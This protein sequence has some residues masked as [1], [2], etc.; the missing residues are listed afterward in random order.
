[1]MKGMGYEFHEVFLMKTNI[2]A[3]QV[4]TGAKHLLLPI[5]FL[6]IALSVIVSACGGQ[7]P[8]PPTPLDALTDS[9][10]Y[11]TADD[12]SAASVLPEEQVAWA[13]E[14]RPTQAA[15]PPAPMATP[16]LPP[17]LQAQAFVNLG[18]EALHGV[19]PFTAVFRGNISYQANCAAI[20]LDT[21]D[22]HRVPLACPADE[23]TQFTLRHTYET[24]ATYYAQAIM[25]LADG[26]TVSSPTQTV[27]VAVPQPVEATARILWWSTWLL[28]VGLAAAA[29]WWCARRARRWRGW[30][31]AG[32]GLLLIT[33]VPPF[34]YL[35]DPLGL[36]WSWRGGY[37]EDT[38]LP[39]AN[40]FVQ[41]EATAALRPYL[42]GL[43]G[44][45]GLDPLHPT[46]PLAGYSF[47][48]VTLD[49]QL[50]TDVA[51]N[52]HYADGS[53]CHYA[54]P[55]SHPAA[56][57]GRFYRHNWHYDGLARLRAEHRPLGDETLLTD[58]PLS[59][60]QRLHAIQTDWAT[61]Y[62]QFGYLE[63]AQMQWSPD[64][65]AFF[66]LAPGDGSL[67]WGSLSK[68]PW[69]VADGVSMATWAA[70]GELLYT[71]L[72]P[73]SLP[74]T[75]IYQVAEPGSAERWLAVSGRIRPYANQTGLWY[76]TDEQL[77]FVAY[78]ADAAEAVRPLPQ[79]A[80][81]TPLQLSPDEQWVAY[82]CLTA[83]SDAAALCLLGPDGRQTVDLNAA[84]IVLA[85]Q[86][87]TQR[88]AVGY[89]PFS[90][91]GGQDEPAWL[92]IIA[93]DETGQAQRRQHIQ[94]AP[95][96]PV[97]SI[98]WLPDGKL[99]VQTF[100]YNGRRLLLVEAATARVAD[101]TQPRWDAFFALHPNGQTLLL[102]NGRGVFWQSQLLGETAVQANISRAEQ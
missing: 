62:G 59:T 73:E 81:G 88:L 21:G 36:W 18:S 69:M 65:Q 83:E 35:P 19:P 68:E 11:Q 101:L 57:L 31:L 52:F 27:V 23:T 66:W 94:I 26:T 86:P 96:G 61:R 89:Q 60:P 32:I 58:A 41:G 1:M 84:P 50:R 70:N 39:F 40:R 44:Q 78:G 56:L 95:Q 100:P 43:I 10:G 33:A 63:P 87:G 98:A 55:L 49:Q 8:Y 42:D 64:G 80:P 93:L 99:L 76:A 51:V 14:P 92:D 72:T 15:P 37:V 34:S 9:P 30:G 12:L 17:A 22:G 7:R 71:Q 97:G 6:G 2:L 24:A 77:W 28:T 53:Q 82:S 47:G 74:S 38:Q 5:W 4:R 90:P 29:A 16:I 54:V 3:K 91:F 75:I 67:W 102:H 79:A 20:V 85:W 25:Q 45:T 13:N 48:R 46:E